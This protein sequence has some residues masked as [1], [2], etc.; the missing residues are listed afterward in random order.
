M[1][2]GGNRSVGLDIADTSIEVAV[3][4]EKKKGYRVV[5]RARV[6]LEPGMVERGQIKNE[7]G[8]AKAVNEVLGQVR[9]QKK[10]GLKVVFGL[11]ESQVYTHIFKLGKHEK[12]DR[13]RLV[14][15]E[16]EAHV[17]VKDDDL[18]F[19]YGVLEEKDGKTEMLL[20][21]VSTQIFEAWQKFFGKLNLEVVFDVESLAIFRGLYIERPKEPIG[22]ID[23]GANTTN[24]GIFG[25]K[26]L[27]FTMVSQVGGSALT[28][29]IAKTL[30]V[31]VEEAEKLKITQ[32]LADMGQ[33]V[34]K[35]LEEEL[36][37]LVK[38]IKQSLK[39]FHEESGEGVIKLVLV[40]GGSKLPGL[41]E[42]LKPQFEIDVLLAES[43]LLKDKG[44]LEYIEAIGLALRGFNRPQDQRDPVLQVK[45][46]TR[47]RLTKN[48][49]EVIRKQEEV[50]SLK[51]KQDEKKE[52]TV[53]VTPEELAELNKLKKEKKVLMLVTGMGVLVLLMAVWFRYDQRARRQTLLKAE[54]TEK[55]KDI[56]QV[57]GSI[58]KQSTEEKATTDGTEAATTEEATP[59][60]KLK[61]TLVVKETPT[62][63]L[64]VRSG[65]GVSYERLG[66]VSPEEE[67][68]FYEEKEGW[69]KILVD[70]TEGWVS[71]DYVEI[72]GE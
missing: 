60:A 43:E 65:P 58:G 56:E 4:K 38:E 23:M 62:G 1:L 13:E 24:M 20:V 15:E 68:G 39:Y 6:I 59:A 71:G 25:E 26:G 48:V 27:R 8:L 40:G 9:L 5:G 11:P 35:V 66:R 10:K 14:F 49:G 29:K 7:E 22:V 61:G 17:P 44:D 70:G 50:E 54:V 31:A 64:S 51:L 52:A 47:S 46:G 45:S 42:W 53:L 63:W 30:N 57:E 41:I 37:T 67:Y 16:A 33:Q 32:G 2:F 21:A 19:S 69:L 3:V 18:L 36:K 12:K 28:Q 72:K 55:V 34:A